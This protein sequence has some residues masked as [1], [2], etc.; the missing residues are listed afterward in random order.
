MM[1]PNKGNSQLNTLV[2]IIDN[3]LSRIS[4]AMPVEVLAVHHNTVDVIPLVT[5]VDNEGR[6]VDHAPISG[7]PYI[8]LQAGDYGMII[9]PQVG[10]KGL[11]VFAARDI[12]H[13]IQSKKKSLPASSRKHSISDGIYIASLLYEEPKTY[14]KI[15]KDLVEVQASNINIKGDV[16]IDG[17]VKI[18]GN[19]DIDQKVTVGQDAV[20]HGISFN[21][22]KHMVIKE[23]KP[24]EVPN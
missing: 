15:T 6:A 3:A 2:S 9:D 16:S 11:V 17:N 19:M 10:D 24:T 7:L 18:T 5:M 23:G 1:N 20:I 4:T 14:I 13:V 12:S 21:N 8:R 22:H